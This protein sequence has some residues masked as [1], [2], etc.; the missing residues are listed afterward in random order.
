MHYFSSY[1]GTLFPFMSNSFFASIPFYVFPLVGAFIIIVLALKG[2]ALWNAARAGQ[3]GWFIA[4]LIL[5]TAGLLEI[6]YLVWFRPNS[7]SD[8]K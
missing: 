2:F 5:N 1:S 6:I 8:I 4:L 3:T 7:N